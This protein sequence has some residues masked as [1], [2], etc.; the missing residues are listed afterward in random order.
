[1]SL[2]AAALR[3]ALGR[4][5]QVHAECDSTNRLARDAAAVWPGPP[6]PGPLVVA[7]HQTAGRGR[8]GRAWDA[9]AGQNL[10]FSIVLAPRV[11]PDRAARCVMIWAAAM[12][13]AL[14]VCVK[15]PND[16]VT[17]QHRKLGGI[18]AEL[19]L[20]A[21]GRVRHIVLGV[22]VNVN[23]TDF[24][25]LPDATSLATERGAPQDRSAVLVALVRA[26]ESAP[27][28]GVA[29][30]DLWRRRSATLGRTVSVAGVAG[31]A[32][33]IRDDGALI[34][35]GQAVLTGDVSLLA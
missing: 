20:D 17:P 25:G 18:L 14:D 30:L 34:V 4:A 23:Q 33:D 12:A 3:L 28:V 19:E 26:V 31:I 13:E 5:V 8:R 1:M 6:V 7:E 16:L 21:S 2:D 24:P 15:W 10:L 29:G 9:V 32:E 35:G 11:P 27:V 22:G